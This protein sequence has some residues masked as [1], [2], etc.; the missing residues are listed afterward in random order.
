MQ[1]GVRKED[2]ERNMSGNQVE[3]H[4]PVPE[5]TKERNTIGIGIKLK[6][7]QN[8]PCQMPVQGAQGA[9]LDR[10]KKQVYNTAKARHDNVIK[11]RD[12]LMNKMLSTLKSL[13]H[14]SIRPSFEEII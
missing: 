8:K 2:V 10:V 4:V 9:T 7:D 6:W 14:E 5:E 11:M 12:K 13:K 3:S 1:Q